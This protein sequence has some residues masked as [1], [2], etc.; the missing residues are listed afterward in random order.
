MA[1][2]VTSGLNT[3]RYLVSVA[4]LMTLTACSKEP[5]FFVD[6]ARQRSISYHILAPDESRDPAPLI[7]FSHGSG[8]DW[9]NHEWLMRAL[10]EAGFLTA[11]VNHPGNTTMDNSNE[12]VVQ[13]WQRPQDL[14]KLLD[15]LLSDSVWG[16]RI[17]ESRIGAAG[18]S[19]GGYTV[20]ALAGAEY[21]SGLLTQYCAQEDHG[22]DCNLANPDLEV[23][24][25]GSDRSFRDQRVAAVFAMAPA[26]GPAITA[27][28]LALLDLPVLIVAAK[29]DE[30]V[31]P[32]FSAEHYAKHI[33][34]AELDILPTG[35]HFIFLECNIG[36]HIFDWF[37]DTL[38]LCGTN[39]EV[40]RQTAREEI[41]EQ[42]VQFFKTSLSL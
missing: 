24:L 23:D 31:Y 11:A 26:V 18:F 15:H 21:Q 38:D 25:S 7:I 17:D 30:L 33:P 13:V 2:S 4:L 39:F 12:G 16:T 9:T 8:G 37:I 10:V 20:I 14:T 32:K 19:S 3:M 27:E 36:T 40:D 42:A 29:D 22:P 34:G 28:S 41:A 35:G 5:P 6:E 1:N